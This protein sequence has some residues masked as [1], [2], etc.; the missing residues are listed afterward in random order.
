MDRGAHQLEVVLIIFAL[1]AMY[2][3]RVF[4]VRGN[5]E[6]KDDCMS[7]YPLSE[8]VG[9]VFQ[10]PKLQEEV[11]DAIYDAFSFLPISALVNRKILVVHGG[12]GGGGF[13]LD[14]LRHG[15]PRPLISVFDDSIPA[16]IRQVLWSDPT[17]SD[18]VDWNGT[19]GN[20][21]RYRYF[22]YL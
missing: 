9:R 21:D 1:K 6:F 22:L 19:H 4:L 17:T 5:H 14:D 2:P 16:F 20:K 3:G 18:D 11:C 12:I 13:S 10:I 15:V 8:A 7:P